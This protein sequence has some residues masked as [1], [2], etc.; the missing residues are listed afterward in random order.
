MTSLLI[1]LSFDVHI[2]IFSQ[3]KRRD[4]CLEHCSLGPVAFS[5]HRSLSNRKALT[6]LS[7]NENFVILML[8]TCKRGDNHN[9]KTTQQQKYHLYLFESFSLF[10]L[11]VGCTASHVQLC[12]VKITVTL[13]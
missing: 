3:K 6:S 5:N 13:S 4:F 11:V 1:S 7:V 9:F 12:Q 2:S 10:L 8:I